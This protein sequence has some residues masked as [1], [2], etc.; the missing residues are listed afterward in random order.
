LNASGR[1]RLEGGCGLGA[2]QQSRIEGARRRGPACGIRRDCA[3][4]HSGKRGRG[5][6]A[7]S[8]TQ[9]SP[10]CLRART[11]LLRL[12]DARRSDRISI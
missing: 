1:P 5:C 6:D 11:G 12:Y 4:R 2:A 9:G 10:R 7:D 8:A 3:Q